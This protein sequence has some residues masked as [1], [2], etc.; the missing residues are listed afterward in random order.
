[1]C[2]ADSELMAADI[3]TKSFPETKR[4]VW[5]SNLQ[6]INIY[7]SADD[8]EYCPNT[9]RSVR[10]DMKTLQLEKVEPTPLEEEPNAK[11]LSVPAPLS[12]ESGGL[13]ALGSRNEGHYS[14]YVPPHSG[15]R[16]K[17]PSSWKGVRS[18]LI[19]CCASE[20]STL[21][22][23]SELNRSSL[24][25]RCAKDDDMTSDSS[26]S[27]LVDFVKQIPKAVVIALW[28]GIPCAGGSPAQNGNIHR[29][30]HKARM[31]TLHRV[32]YQLL[33]NY[34]KV[35]IEVLKRGGHLVM[36]WPLACRYWKEPIVRQLL[37]IPVWH[38]T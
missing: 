20:E 37:S 23:P 22:Q 13:V 1:M 16:F 6:L 18:V 14:G 19:E 10:G 34:V 8:I 11:A 27:A 24:L 33:R 26:V 4:A 31:A 7:P 30:G 28:S 21:C 5:N 15:S 12:T 9:S 3:F 38:E 2:R 29:P 17:A 36:E 32:W 25:V 35:A